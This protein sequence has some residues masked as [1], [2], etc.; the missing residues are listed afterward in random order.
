MDNEINKQRS[1]IGEKELKEYR[2]FAL[3]DDMLKLAIGVM[4]GNSF[5]K[6][7]YGFSDYLVMPVFKFICSKT[8]EGWRSWSVSPVEGLNFELG[9]L[10][11][12][13]TDFVLIS[14]LL[15]VVYS[16]ML[17]RVLREDRGV[18][19]KKQCPLCYSM[20]NQKATKCPVCTGDLNVKPR[21]S[22]TKDK[23][24]KSRRGQ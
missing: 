21:R 20:I 24:T 5:N 14:V 13:M 18:V 1:L 2:N 8:G 11:G 19:E 16:K 23:G 9:R 15:Y 10:L 6:V 3:R 12:T 4:L 22:R 17:N 7:V